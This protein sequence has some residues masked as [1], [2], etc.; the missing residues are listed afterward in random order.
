MFSLSRQCCDEGLLFVGGEGADGP[1][2]TIHLLT[3]DGWC[4]NLDLPPLPEALPSPSVYFLDWSKLNYPEDYKGQ[5]Q[6]TN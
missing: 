5:H 6:T 3:K 1:L 2:D 4:K